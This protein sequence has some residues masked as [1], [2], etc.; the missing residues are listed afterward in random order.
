[1]PD[2]TTFKKAC[3]AKTNKIA[4]PSRLKEHTTS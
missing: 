3:I 4:K 1:M 2:M